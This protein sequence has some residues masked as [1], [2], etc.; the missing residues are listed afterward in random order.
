M[1]PIVVGNSGATMTQVT[2][3]NAV[4]SPLSPAEAPADPFLFF[5]D[6]LAE[7]ERTE[8]NDPTAMSLA[9]V[10]ADGRPSLRIV[11]L[12]GLDERGFVFYTNTESRKGFQ[13]AARPV[14]ALCFHWKSLRRQVRIEG[15]V[16]R[17]TEAE[18][19]AYFAS[20]P[21]GSRIGAWAS[22]QSR[23]LES[24]AVLQH[25]VAETEARYDGQEVPRPP[26]WSG[27]RV[28]PDDIEF[29]QDGEFRL[30]D[31]FRYRRSATGW[32]CQRLYP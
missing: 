25:R 18:A 9:T 4:P 26:H 7:A 23:P 3:M 24:R 28:L 10:D 13:L 2:A 17:V 15:A 22:Q 27:Y 30:H 8:P 29:W 21:R 6:W 31:R 14:A 1:F 16:E 11:L 12:K 20:R 19:D 32:T 5:R